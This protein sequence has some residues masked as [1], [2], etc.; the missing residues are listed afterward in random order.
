MWG[1]GPMV[2]TL[3]LTPEKHIF[4][5]EFAQELRKEGAFCKRKSALETGTSEPCVAGKPFV[6][7]ADAK[8]NKKP[9]TWVSCG[10]QSTGLFPYLPALFSHEF[11]GK[12]VGLRG[13]HPRQRKARWTGQCVELFRSQ[14]AERAS[15]PAITRALPIEIWTRFR[16]QK[17]PIP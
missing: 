1:S 4:A 10:K 2:L 9:H 3:T 7:F 14:P 15:V 16:A 6:R 8:R 11:K 17:A 5:G 12:V 13:P